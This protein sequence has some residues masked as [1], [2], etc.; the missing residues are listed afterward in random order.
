V[1]CKVNQK[2]KKYSGYGGE[3]KG[4]SLESSKDLG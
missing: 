3:G 4:E 2:D 1:R